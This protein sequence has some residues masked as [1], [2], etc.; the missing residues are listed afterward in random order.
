MNAACVQKPHEYGAVEL[1]AP[2]VYLV[3]H[4]AGMTFDTPAEDP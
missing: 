4:A 2:E 1:A 3:W